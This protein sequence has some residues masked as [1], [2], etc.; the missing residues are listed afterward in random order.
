LLSLTGDSNKAMTTG[1]NMNAT[2]FVTY[3]RGLI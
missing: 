3:Y 1:M 2:S